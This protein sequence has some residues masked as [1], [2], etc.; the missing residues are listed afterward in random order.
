MAGKIR[1]ESLGPGTCSNPRED[2]G[3]YREK[4]EVRGGGEG[5]AIN[6][7]DSVGAKFPPAIVASQGWSIV[8]GSGITKIAGVVRLWIL[9]SQQAIEQL[10]IP[11]LR[12]CWQS[13]GV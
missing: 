10:A 13:I 11:V 6:C 4:G 5:G 9:S 12:W 1:G 2:A 8:V 3:D 7:E